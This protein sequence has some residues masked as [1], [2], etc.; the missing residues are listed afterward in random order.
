[1]NVTDFY[2][3]I[4]RLTSQRNS[5]INTHIQ[6]TPVI[7]S[8]I[9]FLLWWVQTTGASRAVLLVKPSSQFLLCI[10]VVW[11]LESYIHTYVHRSDNNIQKNW[12]HTLI[13]SIRTLISSYTSNSLTVNSRIFKF[14][15]ITI[16]LNHLF[17]HM[18]VSPT[19]T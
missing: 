19:G 2:C 8:P 12:F 1:M 14:S 5:F 16:M 11:L 3:C 18:Y 4:T 10:Y 15:C 7:N 6:C 17:V 13:K 9:Y